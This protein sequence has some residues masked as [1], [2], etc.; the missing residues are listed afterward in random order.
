MANV[1]TN[2]LSLSNGKVAC[3][4]FGN[5]F[6]FTKKEMEEIISLYDVVTGDWQKRKLAYRDEDGHIKLF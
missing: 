1:T 3:E 6:T 4:V 2:Y 5:K